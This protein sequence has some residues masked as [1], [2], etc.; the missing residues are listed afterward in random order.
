MDAVIDVARISRD[1]ALSRGQALWRRGEA[2]DFFVFVDSGDIS[3]S[4]A[5]SDAGV[6]PLNGLGFAEA[7]LGVR[8]P[9]TARTERDVL[10]QRV[11]VD[12]FLAVLET[13]FTLAKNVLREL[14]SRTVIQA[15]SF[16]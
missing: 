8:R 2:A 1:V 12:A 3:C 15:G 5:A 9:F 13:H 16:Q 4:N 10:V 14:A 11:P 7:V 6:G